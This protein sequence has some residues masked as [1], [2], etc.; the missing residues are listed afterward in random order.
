VAFLDH[1]LPGRAPALI[2][3][4]EALHAPGCHC[5]IATGLSGSDKT[6]L[7][8]HLVQRCEALGRP[9]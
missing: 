9:W 8:L 5:L 3:V 6:E 4:E 1:Q 2:T 7:L